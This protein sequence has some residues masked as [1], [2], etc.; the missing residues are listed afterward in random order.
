MPGLACSSVRIPPAST[1][2]ETTA[3]GATT[4]SRFSLPGHADREGAP[5]HIPAVEGRYD[6]LRVFGTGHVYK[7]KAARLA[8]KTIGNDLDIQNLVAAFFKEGAELVLIHTEGE[9]AYVHSRS[10]ASISFS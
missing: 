4:A 10:H 7:G 9:I 6:R 5:A 2:A 1:T 8:G 3:A